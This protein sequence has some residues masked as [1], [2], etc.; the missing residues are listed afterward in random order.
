MLT[1]RPGKTFPS[2]SDATAVALVG[3]M[4]LVTIDRGMVDTI[5]VRRITRSEVPVLNGDAS[6]AV[7][8]T[9]DLPPHRAR[10]EFFRRQG[11]DH[12]G[13]SRGQ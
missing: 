4:V 8:Q 2:W 11:R 9:V 3:L 5:K 10:R 13:N 6:N 12:G 1:G 7:W